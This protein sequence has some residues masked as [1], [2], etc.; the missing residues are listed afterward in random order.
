[1]NKI[2]SK[3]QFI[4]LL[5]ASVFLVSCIIEDDNELYNSIDGG[6]DNLRLSHDFGVVEGT[7][8]SL[9]ITPADSSHKIYY[10]TNGT[11]ASSLFAQGSETDGLFLYDEN[12]IFLQESKNPADYAL[13]PNVIYDENYALGTY[14]QGTYV[15]GYVSKGVPL[16]LIEV[17]K[18]NNIVAEK[19]G[20]FIFHEDGT[21]HFGNVPV[22]C[23]SASVS[24]WIG[25]DKISG[26]Y[27]SLSS[28]LKIRANLEYYNYGAG[29]NFSLNTQVK[30]GGNYTKNLPSRTLNLNFK[31]D[32]NGNKNEKPTADI[33]NGRKALGTGEAIRG[34]VK[35]FRLHSGGNDAFWSHFN[36]AFIQRLV[37]LAE[38]SVA[39]AS[40]RPCV[41]Y[42]NGEYWGVYA[43]REHYNEDY[44]EYTFGVDSDDVVYVDKCYNPVQGE[45]KYNFNVKTD[46][47]ETAI[48][49]LDEL[50]EFLGITENSDGTYLFE[51]S[52]GW[53]SDEVYDEFCKM[54]DVD[55]LIDIVLIRGYAEDYDFMFNNLRMWRTIPNPTKSKTKKSKFSDGKWRFMI[56]DTDLGLFDEESRKT[57]VFNGT[58]ENTFLY[59]LGKSKTNRDVLILPRDHRILSLPAQNEKFKAR[60]WER[61]KYI[62][63]IF[64]SEKAISVLD[65][66]QAEIEPFYAEKV[67][68]WGKTDYTIESWKSAVEYRRQFLRERGDTF[69]SDVKT[70]FGIAE[71]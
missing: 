27:N 59:Y 23:L 22:V 57:I 35:R 20:T 10:T 56:H 68:R 51:D 11:S 13:T 28:N 45:S 6:G 43:L 12:G 5:L 21:E 26:I 60:L 25:T 62:K 29:E 2:F 50:H 71:D 14:N 41:L 70:A 7:S 39:T 1:M 65:E 46:D 63:T 30:L 38:T 9:T 36:D 55:S 49:L 16:S 8:L 67:S 31:K 44:I 18:N 64:E 66:M 34:K 17:D 58:A 24:D 37:S 32:E 53:I 47:L 33:F 15:Y 4:S 19:R 52:K 40:Y 48:S 61:A 3:L 42:L 69:L 54:V